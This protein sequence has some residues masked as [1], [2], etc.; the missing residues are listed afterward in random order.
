VGNASFPN[1][2]ATGAIRSHRVLLDSECFQQQT[3]V[4]SGA[5]LSPGCYD[6]V[7]NI[8]DV[9]VAPD[10]TSLLDANID[11]IDRQT[12]QIVTNLR[13]SGYSVEQTNERIADGSMSL[14]FTSELTSGGLFGFQRDVD[15][16]TGAPT[17]T[18]RVSAKAAASCALM[19]TQ[20]A[21]NECA[22]EGHKTFVDVEGVCR[23]P[24]A[25]ASCVADHYGTC[26]DRR[27]NL[28]L[29]LWNAG[30]KIGTAI[31]TGIRW[32]NFLF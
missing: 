2:T 29:L 19:C 3:Q 24:E 18:G 10:G 11:V 5:S 15:P 1:S 23:G 12:K 32:W 25:A 20:A 14:D 26:W 6:F 8:R 21:C 30:L 16:I 4:P 13:A 9:G 31:S 22:A 7:A 28:I 17:G 27:C